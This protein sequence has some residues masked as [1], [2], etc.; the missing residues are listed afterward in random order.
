MR[1]GLVFVNLAR[2]KRVGLET[3]I[4]YISP[5]NNAG[6]WHGASVKSGFIET[7]SGKKYNCLYLFF[8]A[9]LLLSVATKIYIFQGYNIYQ[10]NAV[11]S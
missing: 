3:R 5:K 11:C 4:G 10:L 1:L 2:R 9:A 7:F 8:L 6:V